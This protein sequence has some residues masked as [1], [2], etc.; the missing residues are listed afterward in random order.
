MDDLRTRLIKCF[1]AVFPEL[2][3]GR[4]PEASVSS[5]KEWDSLAGVTFLTV[6]EEEFGIQ[7]GLDDLASMVSFEKILEYLQGVNAPNLAQS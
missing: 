2:K 4:I 7:I 5:V 3:E 6:I 1:S